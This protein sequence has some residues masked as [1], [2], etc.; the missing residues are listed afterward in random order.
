MKWLLV[1]LVLG[2]LFWKWSSDRKVRLGR[3]A[4]SP[5]IQSH[6]TPMRACSRCGLNVPEPDAVPGHH[7]WYC[8]EDHRYRAEA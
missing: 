1:L 3:R 8:C 2:V 7:G 4:P 6:S 5:P